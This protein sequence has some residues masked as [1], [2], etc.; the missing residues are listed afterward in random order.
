MTDEPTLTEVERAFIIRLL[1]AADAET[2]HAYGHPRVTIEHCV[3]EGWIQ[4]D[5]RTVDGLLIT[6]KGR[7]ALEAMT[8]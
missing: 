4:P 2:A 7:Q 8:K 1:R 5:T 6:T 3:N